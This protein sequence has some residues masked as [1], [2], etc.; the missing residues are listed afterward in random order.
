M[1]EKLFFSQD[2]INSWTDDTRVKFENDKLSI[3]S[4]HGVQE[5]TLAPAFRFIHV[6]DDTPDPHNLIDQVRTAEELAAMG[7]EPYLTSC[8]LGETAYD[9]EPGYVASKSEEEENL[10]QLLMEYLA[11]TLI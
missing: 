3:E 4:T 5:Y 2:L 9:V 6:S 1:S 7:A 11:K 10:N 8:I